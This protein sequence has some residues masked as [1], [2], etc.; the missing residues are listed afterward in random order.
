M[1]LLT[2]LALSHPKPVGDLNPDVPPALADLV[3]RLL[4][5]KPADRPASAQ[6]VVEALQAVER[7]FLDGRTVG[8]VHPAGIGPAARLASAGRRRRPFILA[9]AAAAFLAAIVAAAVVVIIRDK[10]G[11]KT[12]EIV[13][14]DGGTILI[15]PA[16]ELVGAGKAA[17][18]S[19]DAW[20]ERMQSLPPEKQVKEVVD[21]LKRLNPAFDGGVAPTIRDGVVTELEFT[22]DNI[23]NVAP[24]RAAEVAKESTGAPEAPRT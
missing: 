18:S 2:G 22:T 7:P 20:V 15:R 4:A 16:E 13:L 17:L 23:T 21:E 9:A 8:H 19:D 6:A 12:A 10:N 14:P 11:N 24:V 3:M 1:A 5:K